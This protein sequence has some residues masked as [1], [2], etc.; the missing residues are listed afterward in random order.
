MLSLFK[1][2]GTSIA[3]IIHTAAQ[4]SHDWAARDPI[5]DFTVNANGTLNLLEMTR[6]YCPEAVF[7]FTSTNKVYGDSPNFLPLVELE[8]RWELQ[9]HAFAENGIDESMNID[10]TKHS[11]FG[12]SK[13]AADVMVQEYGRYF[14]LNTGVFR[15]GCLTGPAHYGTELHGFLAY[16]AKCAV[17]GKPYNVFGYKGKQVRYNIHSNDLV[18]MFCQFFQHPKPGEVN[19]IGGSR[20]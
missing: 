12:V 2:Y 6:K 4:P 10:Q 8:S 1:H 20:H 9:D 11:L 13:L 19:N 16:L 3:G 5:M 17:T 7:L 18:Q 14:G 15:G